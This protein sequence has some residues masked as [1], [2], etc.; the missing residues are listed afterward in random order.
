MPTGR[1]AR[2]SSRPPSGLLARF[3]DFLLDLGTAVTALGLALLVVAVVNAPG[4]L[5]G[6]RGDAANS[7]HYRAAALVGSSSIWWSAHKGIREGD[8]T[9]DAPA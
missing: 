8:F 3:R 7:P 6:Q 5:S 9:V 1:Q 2:E 4:G